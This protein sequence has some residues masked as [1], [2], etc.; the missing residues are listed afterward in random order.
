MDWCSHKLIG[1]VLPHYWYQSL[2]KNWGFFLNKKHEQFVV[3]TILSAK[4]IPNSSMTF[5]K[6][7]G[8]YAI[9]TSLTHEHLNDKVYNP[10]S[11][12]AY[13]ECFQLQRGN[14]C[15]HQIKIILLLHP[16]IVKGTIAHYYDSLSGTLNNGLSSMFS[17][18]PILTP[19]S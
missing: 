13:C 18:C 17:P 2:R 15:K 8:G 1:N 12:W 14:I 6:D 11:K 9:V 19:F 16:D 4:E 10:K 3:N 5:P 7:D